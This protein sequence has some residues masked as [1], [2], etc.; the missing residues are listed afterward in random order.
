[1]KTAMKIAWAGKKTKQAF[2][3]NKK[4][5]KKR[6]VM[7]FVCTVYQYVSVF[8]TATSRNAIKIE[9]VIETENTKSGKYR[10]LISYFI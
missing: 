5:E 10:M 4:E 6:L 3:E 1:M 2:I 8:D 9:G 7:A